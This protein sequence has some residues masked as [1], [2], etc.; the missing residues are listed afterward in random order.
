MSRRRWAIAAG[1][2]GALLALD[3]VSLPIEP[4]NLSTVGV[5]VRGMRRTVMHGRPG[6]FAIVRTPHGI[7]VVSDWIGGL[8]DG[9]VLSG[10][11]FF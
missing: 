7:R 9:E 11:G 3:A 2:L 8:P 4:D 6:P 1:A 10:M 5:W